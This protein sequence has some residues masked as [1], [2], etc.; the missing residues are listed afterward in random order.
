MR[1]EEMSDEVRPAYEDAVRLS[2]D[3][4]LFRLFTE[5]TGD[6]EWFAKATESGAETLAGVGIDVP[7]SLSVSFARHGTAHPVP[8][9]WYPFRIVLSNCRTFYRINREKDPPVIEETEE[10]CFTFTIVPTPQPGGPWG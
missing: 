6:E 3:P 9:E 5:L 10:V 8:G 2:E 4:E 7:A 1:R